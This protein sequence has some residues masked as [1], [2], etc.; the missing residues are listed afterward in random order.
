MFGRVTAFLADRRPL[1]GEEYIIDA[2]WPKNRFE[3][4][5]DRILKILRR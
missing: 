1:C 3:R 2:E 5:L 4:F